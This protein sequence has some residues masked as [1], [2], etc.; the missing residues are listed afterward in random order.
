MNEKL[1]ICIIGEVCVDLTLT[2]SSRENKLRFG[3]VVHAARALWGLDVPYSMCYTGPDYFTNAVEKFV[4]SH[5]AIEVNKIG[6]VVGSPNLILIGEPKEIGAQDYDFILRDEYENTFDLPALTDILTKQS[7]SDIV[8]YAGLYTLAPIVELCQ[9]SKARIHIDLGNFNGNL[10]D[11]PS[12]FGKIDTIFLSTSSG[13]FQKDYHGAINE[14][15]Y[16]VLSN[17]ANKLLFKENRGGCRLF[18]NNQGD[19]V[20]AGAQI[21]SIVHSVGVGDCFDVA[22]LVFLNQFDT[23]IALNYA[24]WIAA[25][26]AVTTFPDDFRKGC[27]RVRNLGPDEL[28]S[29]SGVNLPWENRSSRDVYI[30]APD[31]DYKDRSI[32]NNV[33]DCLKYNNFTPRLPIRENGQ[34]GLEASEDRKEK[35]FEADLTLIS[36]CAL[37][38][39]IYIE[40]DPGTLIEIGF[41]KAIGKPVFVYDP[42]KCAENLMLTQLPDIIS[43]DLDYIISKVFDKFSRPPHE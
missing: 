5:G 19:V 10:K 30:A 16:D 6:T 7:F 9:Q 34:M 14:L 2:D 31:F 22:Y 28:M 27:D 11:L 26:Y 24:S 18:N 43:S 32:I 33:V 12:G 41:A 17:Y 37:I 23:H 13:I 20:T 21:R 42:Y 40:N 38:L 1:N 4:L 29:L 8:I 15:C 25:E 35:L 3:G 39:A 36:D